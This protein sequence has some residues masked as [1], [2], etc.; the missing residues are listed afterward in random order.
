[1][2]VQF[3]KF[4]I[5]STFVKVSFTMCD[6]LVRLAN[7]KIVTLKNNRVNKINKKSG[8][9]VLKLDNKKLIKTSV[10]EFINT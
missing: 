6:L 1:M 2:K 3:F 5:F 7:E 9:E 8:E 10:I 4:S